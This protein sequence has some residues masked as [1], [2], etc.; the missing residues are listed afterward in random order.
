MED[1]AAQLR[2]TLRDLNAHQIASH[3]LKMGD[4]SSMGRIDTYLIG[5]RLVLVQFLNTGR[6]NPP[7]WDVFVPVCDDTLIGETLDALCTWAAVGPQTI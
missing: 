1:R 3:P 6:G 2:D 5:T 4:G 7:S